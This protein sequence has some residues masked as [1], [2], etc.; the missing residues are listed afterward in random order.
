MRRIWSQREEK[1]LHGPEYHIAVL[2]AN[3]VRAFCMGLARSTT[4]CGPKLY[5]YFS[6]GKSPCFENSIGSSMHG[7]SDYYRK[8]EVIGGLLTN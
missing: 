5:K 2:L 8:S 4:M 1:D 6:K 7:I 3:H